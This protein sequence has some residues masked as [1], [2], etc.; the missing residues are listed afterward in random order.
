MV[1]FAQDPEKARRIDRFHAMGATFGLLSQGLAWI[2]PENFQIIQIT[3]W[4]LA[5]RKDIGIN[6][7]S[8]TVDFY[9]F[10]PSGIDRAL[11]LPRD[12]TVLL[13]F[14]GTKVRNTHR[15]SHYMLFRVDVK[16]GT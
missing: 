15:Y 2:D 9:P 11:W 4:L 3:T 1:G 12:V 7:Q 16:S 5:P 6:S 10:Q 13:D 14:M 8:T